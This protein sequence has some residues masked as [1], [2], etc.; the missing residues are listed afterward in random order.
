MFELVMKHQPDEDEA[1]KPP[2]LTHA[3]SSGT[4]VFHNVLNVLLTTLPC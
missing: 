3:S 2:A 1:K 4:I